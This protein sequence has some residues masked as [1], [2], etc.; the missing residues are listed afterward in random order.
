MPMS[1][2]FRIPIAS[3]YAAISSGGVLP[4]QWCVPFQSWAAVELEVLRKRE[5]KIVLSHSAHLAGQ[6]LHLFFVDDGRDNVEVGL[7]R[8]GAGLVDVD[9]SSHCAPTD[10]N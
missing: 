8:A 4:A 7:A 9:E 3:W 1:Q 5:A 2:V 10:G 6:R